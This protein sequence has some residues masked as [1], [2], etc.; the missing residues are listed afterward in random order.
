MA[1]MYMYTHE[2]PQRVYSLII[3]TSLKS[4]AILR[5]KIKHLWISKSRFQIYFSGIYKLNESIIK[6]KC[7]LHFRNLMQNG[8]N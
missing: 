7:F 6:K 3:K 4:L 2:R 5:L 8:P 1:I